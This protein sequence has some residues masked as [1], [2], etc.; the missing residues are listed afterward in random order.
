MQTFDVE[1]IL[2]FPRGMLLGYEHR[3]KVPES[4]LDK[5]V[6][7][8]LGEPGQSGG[9]QKRQLLSPKELVRRD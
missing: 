2:H 9:Y 1:C 8:H 7:G 3:V 4:A 6:R 5:A